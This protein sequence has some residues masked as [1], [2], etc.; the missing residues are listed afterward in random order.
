MKAASPL[1]FAAS[2][3]ASIRPPIP[4]SISAIAIL[5]LLLVEEEEF[6]GLL[7]LLSKC[8]NLSAEEVDASVG[9]AKENVGQVVARN[10]RRR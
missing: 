9:R 8:P 4:R 2:N 10:Q 1:A 7:G 6:N 5:L 3:A